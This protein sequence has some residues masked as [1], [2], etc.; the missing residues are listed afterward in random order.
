MKKVPNKRKKPP[1]KKKVR[2]KAK[3]ASRRAHPQG[4]TRKQASASASA[5][6][7]KSGATLPKAPPG[8]TF[9]R[10]PIEEANRADWLNEWWYIPPEAQEQFLRL[11]SNGER[12]R[13]ALEKSGLEWRQVSAYMAQDAHFFEMYE[14]ARKMREEFVA[15]ERMEECDH[16]AIRGWEEPV[17]YQD[18][19]VGTIRRF[20]D[21]LMEL[22]I[23]GHDPQKYAE[24]H[25]HTHDMTGGPERP[26][27][28]ED[29]EKQCE[30]AERAERL[31]RERIEA[32]G[33]EHEDEADDGDAE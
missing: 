32:K 26:A 18:K 13:D 5:R 25:Q 7:S 33:N 24:R 27:S 6:D 8:V 4:R 15:I 14:L 22:R 28:I 17:Y 19:N 9:P 3:A 10:S 23:K 12:H 30:A 11:L 2:A 20:S 21:R 29:W 1:S 16:R 31:K